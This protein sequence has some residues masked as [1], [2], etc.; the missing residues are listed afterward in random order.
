MKHSLGSQAI[1]GQSTEMEA[2]F[3]FLRRRPLHAKL[4]PHLPPLPH[5]CGHAKPHLL[6]GVGQDGGGVR[7]DPAV[8]S[9]LDDP[10]DGSQTGTVRGGRQSRLSRG[11]LEAIFGAIDV[12][13]VG[14]ITHAQFIEGLKRNRGIAQRL[15]LGM[16][17]RKVVD[18]AKRLWDCKYGRLPE[19]DGAELEQSL[20][21]RPPA[22]TLFESYAVTTD[23]RASLTLTQEEFI[24]FH[25]QGGAA[26]VAPPP[27]EAVNA[28]M[29]AMRGAGWAGREG[30]Q[31]GEAG[32]EAGGRGGGDGEV[33]EWEVR[34]IEHAKEVCVDRDVSA[35][36]G[37]RVETSEWFRRSRSAP[38]PQ[39]TNPK[40]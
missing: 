28:E 22:S 40:P 25:Q 26:T 2:A 9:C 29:P 36:V 32:G 12:V 35:R 6:E 21:G 23:L 30:G 4:V 27:D 17:S 19:E 1:A 11:E 3:A 24:R 38:K 13:N 15:G 37:L 20:H 31:R 39:T 7:L 5:G 34:G 14:Y 16:S 33:G 10:E 8:P 18:E